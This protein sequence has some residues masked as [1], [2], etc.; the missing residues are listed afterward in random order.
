MS[1]RG[2]FQTPGPCEFQQQPAADHVA[3]GTVGLSPSLRLAQLQRKLPAV[4]T[5]M[6]SDE[7]ADAIRGTDKA[8]ARGPQA[9]RQL[10]RLAVPLRRREQKRS[11]T[12]VIQVARR[13]VRQQRELSSDNRLSLRYL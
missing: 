4:G 12:R 7:L 6:L 13:M 3:Q 5:R 10:S 2:Q 1:R 9:R 8:E 11:V